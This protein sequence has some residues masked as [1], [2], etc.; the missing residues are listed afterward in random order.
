MYELKHVLFHLLR[1]RPVSHPVDRRDASIVFPRR[2]A[3]T[4]NISLHEY[5][6]KSSMVAAFVAGLNEQIR[7]RDNRNAECAI[8][9][10]HHPRNGGRCR[11]HAWPGNCDSGTPQ[12]RTPVPFGGEQI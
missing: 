8:A 6:H 9:C 2:L 11:F 1:N 4:P 5:T 3:D 10:Q 12:P 7:R